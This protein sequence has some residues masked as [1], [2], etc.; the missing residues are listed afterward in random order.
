MRWKA[1]VVGLALTLAGMSGCKQ[2]CFLTKE[3]YYAFKDMAGVPGC[4]EG[5]PDLSV[6]PPEGIVP[7]PGTVNNPER[8]PRYISLRECIAIA[9]E[10]GTSGLQ[11]S[12]LTGTADDDLTRFA[13]TGI[14]QPDSIRVLALQPAIAGAAIESSLARF[15]AQWNALLNITNTDEPVQGLTS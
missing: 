10:Q 4:L 9:L 8:Q 12:R 5:N 1:V 14:T 13:G 7:A 6:R 2:Q 15:D 11:S 3:D